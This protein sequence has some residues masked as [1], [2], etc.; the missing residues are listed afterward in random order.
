[1]LLI[2]GVRY[3]EWEISNEDELEQM[4][5][6]HAQEIF[7]ENSIY[8]DRK[9]R[10]KSLAGI[11][12]IPDGLVIA[13]G[14]VPQWH[15]VEIE[16]SSHDPYAHI[17]PQVDK[18]LNAIDNRDTRTN[19]IEALY[20]AIS[21]DEYLKLKIR[22]VI[23]PDKDAHKFLFD[24]VARSP[25]MT[26][27]IEKETS[28]LGEALKK[29]AQKKVVMF[30]TFRR[31]KAESVHAHLFEPLFQTG[32]VSST[33]VTDKALQ[34]YKQ[35]DEKKAAD[36]YEQGNH[37]KRKKVGIVTFEELV[38]AGLL[39]DG[40]VLYFFHNKPF[41]G[42]RA[43]VMASFNKLKYEVDGR[44]YSKSELAQNILIKYGFPKQ[45]HG[46]QGPKFW[47]T[48]DNKMLVDLEEK[49]RSQ[50]GERS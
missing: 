6:E 26:I 18:F 37:E 42:E 40:Q 1:M 45:K 36:L 33:Y 39:N 9:Q 27:V 2:D 15:I 14:D 11:G 20:N 44:M 5:I 32:A 13:F 22:R 12:S 28:Q 16:L 25:T 41:K 7:G 21:A 4:V 47:R 10:L 35:V 29:Y 38:Q 31:E 17:V 48:E 43:Q 24:I 30:R 49:I 8:F 3:E 23:G 50:R 34:P 19:I 46:V